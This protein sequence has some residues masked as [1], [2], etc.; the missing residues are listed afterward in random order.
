MSNEE[1]IKEELQKIV[2]EA[3][4][5]YNNSGKRT[6]GQWEKGLEI[7]TS[8]TDTT[9]KG[10]LYSYGYLAGRRKGKQPPTQNILEWLEKKNIHPVE[11]KMKLSSLAF[12]IARKI[13]RE[14]TDKD[15]HLLVFEEILTPERLQTIIDRVT[16]FNVDFFLSEISIELKKLKNNV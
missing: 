3:V 8:S 4:E 14:G 1:I 16:R 6:S 2:D 10:E 11:R 5:M 7:R 13:G 9:A 15:R 12:L